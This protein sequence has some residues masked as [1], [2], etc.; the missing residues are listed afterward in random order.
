MTDQASEN[1]RVR[2][3]TRAD[4]ELVLSWRN[5]PDVRRYMYTQNEITPGEHQRWFECAVQDSRKHLLI[6]ELGTKPLGF[7]NFSELAG[8]GIADWGFYA[9]PDAPKGIGQRLGKVALDHAFNHVKL[10][11]ICGQALAYNERSIRF[12]QALGF[13]QEGVLRD[14]FF[15]GEHYHH[16]ICFGLLSH[17]WRVN[18]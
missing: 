1:S 10:H 3:M 2:P 14:Q 6:F 13:Q 12:H 16:V 5:H 18:P 4:L 15:D 7:V 9:A 8:G 11:K 17:K